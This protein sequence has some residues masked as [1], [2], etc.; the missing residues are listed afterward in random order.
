MF[1]SVCVRARAPCEPIE[2]NNYFSPLEATV[3]NE[4][5]RE[6]RGWRGRGK[7]GDKGSECKS[8]S[9]SASEL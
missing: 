8:G 7:E 9:G 5:R 4:T 6:E 1:E 2:K 3:E